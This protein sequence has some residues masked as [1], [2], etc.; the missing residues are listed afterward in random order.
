[1]CFGCEH[2]I[3]VEFQKC[4]FYVKNGKVYNVRNKISY[5]ERFKH[6]FVSYVIIYSLKKSKKICDY[7][8]HCNP[9]YLYMSKWSQSQRAEHGLLSITNVS[10]FY[11]FEKKVYLKP[12][13]F[14]PV[15]FWS[16]KAPNY[17]IILICLL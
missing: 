14:E 2:P 17:I 3:L 8:C 10:L 16:V 4:C 7:D 15:L 5:Q 6:V 13:L 11:L 1:M 12:V 9:H